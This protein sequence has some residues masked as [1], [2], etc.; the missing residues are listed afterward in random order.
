M[1]CDNS[2][3]STV[4]EKTN[5][6]YKGVDFFPAICQAEL[7]LIIHHLDINTTTLAEDGLKASPR[8]YR[9]PGI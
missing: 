6:G 8:R 7:N 5:N 3:G 2:I 4:A 1:R 9:R